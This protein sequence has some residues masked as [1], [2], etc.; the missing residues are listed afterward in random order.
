MKQKLKKKIFNLSAKLIIYQKN[1]R[2]FIYL[3]EIELY[4]FKKEEK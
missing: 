3:Q 1:I 2:S 4:G